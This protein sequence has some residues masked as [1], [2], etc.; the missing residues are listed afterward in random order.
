MTRAEAVKALRDAQEHLDKA[1][2]AHL[3]VPSDSKHCRYYL[4]G[5]HDAL[6]RVRICGERVVKMD[7]NTEW[8]RVY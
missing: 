6:E 3:S 7:L 4:I 8:E 5:Y 2:R 1:S